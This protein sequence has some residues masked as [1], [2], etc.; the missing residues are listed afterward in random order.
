MAKNDDPLTL[1]DKEVAEI[2]ERA[3][4]WNSIMQ[5]GCSDPFWPDGVNL[6]LVRNHII[7]AKNRIREICEENGLIPPDEID[8]Y[9][10]PQVPDNLF[11]G[12]IESD[13][14]KRIASWRDEL[15]FLDGDVPLFELMPVGQ[16]SMF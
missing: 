7:Y 3:D 16:M 2:H 5:N 12:D 15:V 11:R 8:C 4:R 6:N 10:P 14:G 9:I 13:R 1:L